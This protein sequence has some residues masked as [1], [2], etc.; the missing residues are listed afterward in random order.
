MCVCVHARDLIKGISSCRTSLFVHV[1]LVDGTRVCISTSRALFV[2]GIQ[3]KSFYPIDRV[4]RARPYSM[5]SAQS[6]TSP[7]AE[8]AN[9]ALQDHVSQL[10]FVIEQ[11]DFLTRLESRQADV[12]A[13][14][15]SERITQ[16]T[17]ATAANL[18]LN[19]KVDLCQIIGAELHGLQVLIRSRTLG[20]IFC[21]DLFSQAATAVLARPSPLAVWLASFG[22][23]KLVIYSVR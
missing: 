5:S 9:P 8:P 16:G 1:V 13:S 6:K 2:P 12:R 19:S 10:N 22:C 17:V 21:F 7:D 3:G 4:Q 20:C 15:T 23:V 11:P 14:V 18:A